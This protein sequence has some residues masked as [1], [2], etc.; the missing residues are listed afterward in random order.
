MELP[1]D[2]SERETTQQQSARAN[3]VSRETLRGSGDCRN[4]SLDLARE[5]QRCSFTALEI[6]CESSLEF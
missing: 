4:G 3:T 6:P 5:S 1:V 2:H